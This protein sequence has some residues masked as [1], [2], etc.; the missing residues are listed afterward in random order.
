VES[1]RAKS[2]DSYLKFVGLIIGGDGQ[3]GKPKTG[4]EPYTWMETLHQDGNPT[5]GWEP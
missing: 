2:I 4:W 5:S 3:D 1:M